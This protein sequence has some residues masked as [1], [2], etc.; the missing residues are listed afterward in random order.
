MN[1][2]TFNNAII[3]NLYSLILLLIISLTFNLHIPSVFAEEQ[4]FKNSSNYL[5]S[6]NFSSLEEKEVFLQ[7]YLSFNTPNEIK[8]PPKNPIY[9]ENAKF[10]KGVNIIKEDPFYQSINGTVTS[11]RILNV[12]GIPNTEVSFFENALLNGSITILNQG[13]FLDSVHPNKIIGKGKGI[14]TSFDGQ[15][16]T[17][18][19]VD[20]GKVTRNGSIIYQGFIYFDTISNDSLSFLKDLVGLYVSK[21]GGETSQRSIWQWTVK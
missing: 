2:C 15:S 12:E 8:E 7:K 4:N 17:W 1:F 18:N 21:V 10:E 6:F 16:A 11:T 5:L 19:A 3:T 20:I 13:T 9:T 14:I